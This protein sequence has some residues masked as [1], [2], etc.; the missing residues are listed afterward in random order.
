MYSPGIKEAAWIGRPL[1][2]VHVSSYKN[3]SMIALTFQRRDVAM[4]AWT[5]RCIKHV[6]FRQVDFNRKCEFEIL[7]WN[8]EGSESTLLYCIYTV[9]LPERLYVKMWNLS[10]STNIL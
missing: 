5:L 1:A 8:N 6:S 4:D 7:M 9:Y 10:G 2:R 3:R